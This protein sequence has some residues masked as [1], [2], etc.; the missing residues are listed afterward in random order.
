MSGRDPLSPVE[1]E[2]LLSEENETANSSH[3]G[4][5]K[6]LA[7]VLSAMTQ[8]SSTMSSMENAM[9]RL[10]GAPEDHATPS[11][12]R[13]TPHTTNTMS[14]SGD[15]DP[16]KS[17]SEELNSPPNSDPPKLGS[18]DALLD[19]IAQDF[20]SDEQ[21]DPK[22]AQKLA[23]IV[24]K[25]WSSKLEEAKLKE[26]LA[27]YNSP[28]NCKKLTVPKYHPKSVTENSSGGDHRTVSCAVLA[29]SA[30][31]AIGDET[32]GSGTPCAPQKETHLISISTARLGASTTSEAHTS[33][34]PL[35][36]I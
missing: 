23:D 32:A 11:K 21:T 4:T 1:E 2:N 16:E 19:E 20:E 22:V 35:V 12:R 15:S 6:V 26:K 29:N 33:D 8:M 13:T 30:M 17:D 14:H 24:N 9:K 5:D 10:V 28:D 3:Q 18:S 27:K 31:V 36:R 25:R 7:D 34:M